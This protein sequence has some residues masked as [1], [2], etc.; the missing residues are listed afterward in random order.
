MESNNYLN[1]KRRQTTLNS[2][3]TNDSNY[4]NIN[5]INNVKL[6]RK[7]GSCNNISN[8]NTKGRG[9]KSNVTASKTRTQASNLRK[10]SIQ[11]DDSIIYS[12]QAPVSKVKSFQRLDNSIIRQTEKVISFPD[13]KIVELYNSTDQTSIYYLK[14]RPSDI[15]QIYLYKPYTPLPDLSNY[16]SDMIEV[17]ISSEYLNLSN[18]VFKNGKLY[19]SDIY[20]SNS[21]PVLILIHSGFLLL[22]ENEVKEYEGVSLYFRVSKN[23]SSYNALTKFNIK[24]NKNSTFQGHSIKPEGFTI[25][26]SLG[27]EDNLL[28]YASKM[29]LNTETNKSHITYNPNR[30]KKEDN[31][32]SLNNT[33]IRFN[34]SFE[35]SYQYSLSAIIDKSHDDKSEY[36]SFQLRNKVLYIETQSKRYEIYQIQI[37]DYTKANKEEEKMIQT[38]YTDDELIFEKYEKYILSEVKDPVSKDNKFMLNNKVPLIS[39]T[40]LFK[41]IDWHEFKWGYDSLSIRDVTIEGLRA[42]KLYSIK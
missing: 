3:Y 22:D 28:Q 38:E 19:G 6:G 4:F 18:R 24:S 32:Y 34:L 2:K 25:L 21:D 30:V 16:I 17:R 29:P 31:I 36:L 1:R 5:N 14:E 13:K 26:T 12:K 33:P 35:P 42:F 7:R 11:D 15:T 23:R 20:T 27:S 10:N 40:V 39:S 8:V 37:K 41:M 9:V